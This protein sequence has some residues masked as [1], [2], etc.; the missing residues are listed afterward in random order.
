MGVLFGGD[1]QDGGFPSGFPFKPPNKG[2]P[3][4]GR[5][6][7]LPESPPGRGS[8]GRRFSVHHILAM[9]PTELGRAREGFM[10]ICRFV[11]W[12]LPCGFQKR[13]T[14]VFWG[15]LKQDTAVCFSRVSTAGGW[16][17]EKTGH[18]GL[19]SL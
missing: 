10:W 18:E 4:N 17:H 15:A 8:S 13:K 5:P 3:K 14:T 6:E 16:N 9:E 1:S 7:S 11:T 2:Y 12:H 19:L